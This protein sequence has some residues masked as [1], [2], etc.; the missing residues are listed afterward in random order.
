MRSFLNLGHC[1]F[2]STRKP[3]IRRDI[4][5]SPF[6]N[7]ISAAPKNRRFV[8]PPPSLPPPEEVWGNLLL[9][10]GRCRRRRADDRSFLPSFPPFFIVSDFNL[11]Y[12]ED[13]I[14]ARIPG[15]PAPAPSLR[16]R[17]RSRSTRILE[18]VQ[19]CT[20][21]GLIYPFNRLALLLRLFRVIA[22]LPRQSA[23]SAD[24]TCF[25]LLWRE[26]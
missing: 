5:S 13:K 7:F 16:T 17:S 10:S 18:G 6:V 14:T 25:E 21:W 1:G 22:D 3:N 20:S 2:R 15:S 23:C 11:R 19:F 4:R 8:R 26:L 9:T 24:L 12:H